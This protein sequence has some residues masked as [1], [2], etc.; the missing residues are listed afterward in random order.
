MDRIQIRGMNRYCL[1]G[2][3]AIAAVLNAAGASATEH[4]VL[5]L[6]Y[7]PYAVHIPAYVAKAQG[8]YDKAGLDVEILPGR[9][10]SVGAELVGSG[11]EP[12]GLLEPAA[13][14]AARAQG[15][16]IIVVATLAQDGGLALFATEQSGIK[17]VED[18]KGRNVGVYTGST[19]TIFL[20]ALLK[21]HSLSMDDIKPVTVRSGTDLPLVLDGKID[22]EVTVYTNELTAWHITHPE[23]KLR[24]WRMADL[25]FEMPGTSIVTNETMLKTNPQ[26]V[27]AFTL[28]TIQGL[29][30]ALK[31]PQE[32]VKDIV[33]AVPELQANVETAKWNAMIPAATSPATKKDGLGTLDHAKWQQ[34][35][36]LLATYGAIKA[37][38]DLGALLK[39]ESHS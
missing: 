6:S 30:Y 31:H 16:P 26:L 32:A 38:V 34:L 1:A 33:A 36:T 25:G 35:D 12:F 15:I 29:D 19:T 21:K 7:T 8:Y 11:K 14:L 22:A 17:K 23:L 20:Q 2:I 28:A 18:M 4:V 27:K 39:D 9:G 13:V 5:R 24:I 37:P 3:V 10:S